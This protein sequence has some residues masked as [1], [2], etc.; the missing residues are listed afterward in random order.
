MRAVAVKGGAPGLLK[1]P[2]CT[3][4]ACK[5]CG[6]H[7]YH[8]GLTCAEHAEATRTSGEEEEGA[9]ESF[10]K[11][12]EETGTRQCPQCGMAISKENLQ[13]QRAQYAECHKMLCRNCGIRFCFKCLTR[14]TAT[15][16][17]NCSRKEHGFIDPRTGK[18]L[19]HLRPR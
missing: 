9:E 10:R 6:A 8:T 15:K 17:C 14:L 2:R 11:W 3:A 19:P 7:P 16:S 12:M 13:R 5:D 4:T 18:R 1:C